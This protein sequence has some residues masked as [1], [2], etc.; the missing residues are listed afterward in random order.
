MSALTS[1]SNRRGA[2]RHALPKPVPATFGGFNA[3]LIDFSL[4]G[5]RIEH[6]DR[7]NP[8]MTLPLRFFWRGTEVKMQATL[9][10][11]EMV[12]VHGKPGYVSGLIVCDSAEDA[13]AVVRDIVQWLINNEA[14]KIAATEPLVETAPPPPAI[15]VAE[16]VEE[17][18]EEEVEAMSTQYL[19]CV[20]SNGRWEKLYVDKPKQPAEGF[21]IAAPNDEREADVLCRAYEKAAPD[22]RKAMQARFAK[23]LGV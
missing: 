4:T 18:E 17:V 11:S 5:C 10:R 8:R 16:E 7:M 19:Q 21:T 14:R 15:E 3:T 23:A 22:A 1:D 9:V 2:E 6:L 20:F 12:P 13:P